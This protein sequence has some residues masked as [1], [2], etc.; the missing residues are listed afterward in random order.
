LEA[1][2]GNFFVN[3]L[4]SA[5]WRPRGASF[6]WP[7]RCQSEG[8]QAPMKFYWTN[9]SVGR[10]FNRHSLLRKCICYIR[11]FELLVRCA[12]VTDPSATP[13]KLETSTVGSATRAAF[14][15]AGLKKKLRHYFRMARCICNG[16]G[17]S[18]L[19]CVHC[20]NPTIQHYTTDAVDK[21]S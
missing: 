11:H 7:N 18:D 4:S 9:V 1:H 12:H 6:M 17:L 8:V 13:D 10:E 5:K 2:R 19:L 14:C 15:S 3:L 21:A 20:T 16:R